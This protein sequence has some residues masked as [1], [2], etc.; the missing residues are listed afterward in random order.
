[1]QHPSP[2]IK[3]KNINNNKLSIVNYVLKYDLYKKPIMS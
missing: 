1:M 3:C 2:I